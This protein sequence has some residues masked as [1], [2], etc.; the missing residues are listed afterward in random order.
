VVGAAAVTA[1]D[2]L[3]PPDSIAA[4]LHDDFTGV[5]LVRLRWIHP[6]LAVTTAV[7]LLSI[8]GRLTAPDRARSALRA[9]IVAQIGAGMLNVG[10]LAPVWMQLI[11]LFLADALWISFVVVGVAAL[12]ERS[13][14]PVPA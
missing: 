7:Y 2:T 8:L 11:H 13:R 5:F 9:L 1:S 4:G 10:L 12:A 14:V 6:V 3:F